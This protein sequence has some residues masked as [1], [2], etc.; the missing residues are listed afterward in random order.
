MK[1]TTLILTALV[2]SPTL[3]LALKPTATRIAFAPA[4]GTSLTKTFENKASLTLDSFTMTGAGVQPEME[5]TMTTNQ[6]LVV[7]DEYV[8]VKAGAP[9]KLL[10]TFDELGGDSSMS[11]K[12][13]IMGQANDQSQNMRMKSEFQGKKVA[14]TWNA[15]KS[16]FDKAFEPE[17]E[18]VDLLKELAEDMDFRAYLPEGDVKEGDTWTPDVAKLRHTFS[19]GGSLALVPENTDEASL[20]MGADEMSS[21]TNAIGEKLE[22]E[23]KAKLVAVKDVDGRSCA[24]IHIE[25]KVH[26]SADMTEQARKA[27]EKVEL[28]PGAGSIEIDHVDMEFKFEGEGDLVWDIVG[29]HFRSFDLTGQAT[30]KSEQGMKIDV[31]GR[32][33]DLEQKREMSGSTSYTASAK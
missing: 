30:I 24:T 6:K 2:L 27:M 18:K 21:L 8:S 33:M 3:L 10:R 28:P 20:S 31:G 26:S 17:E 7:S 29:G 4:A 22:G 11:M 13:T 12:M 16:E 14:F 25:I 1:T 32:K 9:T 23:V 15:E 5:M 19:P